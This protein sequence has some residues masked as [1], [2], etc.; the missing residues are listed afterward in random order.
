MD[1]NAV[2]QFI[3]II[4]LHLFY[5]PVTSWYKWYNALLPTFNTIYVFIITEE[6]DADDDEAEYEDEE[7][8]DGLVSAAQLLGHNQGTFV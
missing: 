5:L 7:E 3:V 4:L 1:M 6:L 2:L 8:E